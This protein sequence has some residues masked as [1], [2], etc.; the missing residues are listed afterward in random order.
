MKP[1]YLLDSN[2]CF[3][4]MRHQPPEVADRFA[5]CFVGDVVI[6]A[7]TLAELEYG[8]SCSGTAE[9][10]NRQALDSLLED[11]VAAPFEGQAAKAYGPVRQATR[12][13][14]R[15]ALDKLIAAHAIALGAT[16]VTNNEADFAGYPGLR[17]E[18]WV[19]SP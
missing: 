14:K 11:I 18:N 2:I 19:R 9:A 12:E 13:R 8:V 3:Y 17:V 7:I 5:Q 16:L 1:K 4:L 15:D 6:S 10:Q